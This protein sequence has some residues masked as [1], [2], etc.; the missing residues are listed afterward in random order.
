MIP[1]ATVANKPGHRGEHGISRKTIARGMLGDS[2][3][4]VVTMLACF[5]ICTRGCGRGG[6]PAFPAPSDFRW[7]ECS[8][9]NSRTCGETKKLCLKNDAV[10][11]SRIQV[12]TS[13]NPDAIS[14]PPGTSGLLALDW[15][16]K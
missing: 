14:T 11:N 12:L 6:R 16:R 13:A 3:V 5:F 10:D 8:H 1:P 15:N 9:Q 4:T 2:G 7:A